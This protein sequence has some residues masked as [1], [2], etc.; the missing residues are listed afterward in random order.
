MRSGPEFEGYDPP[1]VAAVVDDA[2]VV[3]TGSSPVTLKVRKG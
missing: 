2:I 3:M 1:A